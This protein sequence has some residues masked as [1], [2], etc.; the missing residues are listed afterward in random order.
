M[1]RRGRE[2]VRQC[3]ARHKCAVDEWNAW[4][5]HVVEDIAEARPSGSGRRAAS[6]VFARTICGVSPSE[7]KRGPRPYF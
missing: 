7:K 5:L 3:G 4:R 6:L 1:S 2:D